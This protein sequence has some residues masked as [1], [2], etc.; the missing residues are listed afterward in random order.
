M[1]IHQLQ[2]SSEGS[3]FYSSPPLQHITSHNPSDL[4]GVHPTSQHPFPPMASAPR[5]VSSAP[6]VQD[7]GYSLNG[8]TMVGQNMTWNESMGIWSFLLTGSADSN[9]V[10]NIVLGILVLIFNTKKW[11]YIVGSPP[12]KKTRLTSNNQTNS[13]NS[14]IIINWRYL[15][16]CITRRTLEPMSNHSKVWFSRGRNISKYHQLNG[17]TITIDCQHLYHDIIM[18]SLLFSNINPYAA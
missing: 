11:C 15:F 1:E 7:D 9:T 16:Q 2:K 14:T 6:G 10:M 4:Q 17:K 8:S 12:P 18:I 5:H 13:L 3:C